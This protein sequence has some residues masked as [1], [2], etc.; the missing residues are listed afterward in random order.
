MVPDKSDNA[1]CNSFIMS[2]TMA[3][4]ERNEECSTSSACSKNFLASLTRSVNMLSANCLDLLSWTFSNHLDNTLGL[5][6][7]PMAMIWV[8]YPNISPLGTAL[9][10]LWKS[11]IALQR[12]FQSMGEASSESEVSESLETGG[13]GF[14]S[15]RLSAF[16]LERCLRSLFL[17]WDKGFRLRTGSSRSGRFMGAGCRVSGFTRA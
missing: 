12:T 3:K 16:L 6:P 9:A 11:C 15:L 2:P 10:R 4:M 13:L 1:V 8:Q 5:F 17:C 14:E 7:E